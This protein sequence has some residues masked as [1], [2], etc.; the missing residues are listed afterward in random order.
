MV[1]LNIWINDMQTVIALKVVAKKQT[2]ETKLYWYK[3]Y[4][5]IE[6]LLLFLY[7]KCIIIMAVNKY[8]I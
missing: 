5:V 1:F 6:G 2:A 4:P 7:R 3:C 8:V